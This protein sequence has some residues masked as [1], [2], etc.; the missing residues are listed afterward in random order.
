MERESKKGVEQKEKG[1]KRARGRKRGGEGHEMEGGRWDGVMLLRQSDC[2]SS[3]PTEVILSVYD[4]AGTST[5]LCDPL[6]VN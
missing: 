3:P 2:L 5:A 4:P 6:T 1:R